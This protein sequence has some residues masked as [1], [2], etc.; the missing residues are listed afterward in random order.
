VFYV[1][2]TVALGTSVRSTAGVAA[3]AFAVMFLPSMIGGLVPLVNELSPTSIGNWALAAATGGPASTLT[4]GGWLVSMLVLV[5]GA[6]LAFDR[7]EF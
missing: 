4:L 6:K 7:Q 3:L 2:L 5:I 1:G